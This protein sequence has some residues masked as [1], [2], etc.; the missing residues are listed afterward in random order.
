MPARHPLFLALPVSFLLRPTPNPGV[1]PGGNSSPPDAPGTTITYHGV[2]L[3]VWSHA[4]AERSAAIRRTSEAGHSCKESTQSCCCAPQEPTHPDYAI[5]AT[6]IAVSN[7][8]KETKKNF[9]YVIKDLYDYGMYPF[10][11]VLL[12]YLMHSI[13]NPKTG[14]STSMISKETYDVVMSNAE[15]LD[16][17]IIYEH[18]ST[19]CKSHCILKDAV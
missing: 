13:V 16:S 2:C 7:L 15:T 19:I 14:Q 11:R 6:C 12:P 3:T 8:H 1:R 17:A 9:S 18:D 10:Y 4:D 5:L